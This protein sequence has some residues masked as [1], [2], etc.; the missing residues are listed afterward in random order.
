[1]LTFAT[2][3][4]TSTANTNTSTTRPLTTHRD[5]VPDEISE[6]DT[7]VLMLDGPS[8]VELSPNTV[9]SNNAPSLVSDDGEY[10]DGDDDAE[11]SMDGSEGEDEGSDVA[12]INFEDVD[13]M[14]KVVPRTALRHRAASGSLRKEDKHVTFVSPVKEGARTGR[15]KK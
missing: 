11:S 6:Q 13:S 9:I 14:D 8:I 1:M 10:E 4:N 2:P 15:S 5:Q 7:D 12:E 3:I